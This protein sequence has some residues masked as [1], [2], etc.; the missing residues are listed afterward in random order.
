MVSGFAD[1]TGG[2]SSS[3]SKTY[4]SSSDTLR[5]R[6]L[7]ESAKAYF[8]D[9]LDIPATVTDEGVRARTV[10]RWVAPDGLPCVGH[11]AGGV[12]FN[13]GHVERELALSCGTA[14]LVAAV[15]AHSDQ[16]A[17]DGRLCS[18]RELADSSSSGGSDICSAAMLSPW[19]FTE[20]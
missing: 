4:S 14:R 2:P 17:P 6:G 9:L 11:V 8:D 10:R 3:N 15:A 13:V 16:D 18:P 5:H 1:V 19:R 20:S 12:Y 7:L